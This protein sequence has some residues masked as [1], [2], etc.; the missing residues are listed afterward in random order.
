[1]ATITPNAEQI[2]EQH[3]FVDPQ[4][5]DYI[6]IRVSNKQERTYKPVGILTDAGQKLYIT[7]SDKIDLRNSDFQSSKEARQFCRDYYK[8]ITVQ[9]N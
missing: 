3:S 5:I 4:Y 7:G 2:A 8:G 6:S 9:T 1:M